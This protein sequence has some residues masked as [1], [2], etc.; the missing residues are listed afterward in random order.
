MNYAGPFC[1]KTESVPKTDSSDHQTCGGC[2]KRG[3]S[4]VMS[5]H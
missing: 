4:A 3:K 5:Y 1:N 2:D